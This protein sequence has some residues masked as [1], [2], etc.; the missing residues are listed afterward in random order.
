VTNF[1]KQYESLPIEEKLRRMEWVATCYAAYCHNVGWEDVPVLDC[2]KY[3]EDFEETLK[4][5]LDSPQK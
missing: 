2:T 1:Q 5:H 4:E 3:W